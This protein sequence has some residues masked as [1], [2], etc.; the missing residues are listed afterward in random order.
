MKN[1]FPSHPCQMWV[2]I[3]VFAV[4]A[5]A[6]GAAR[7]ETRR[8]VTPRYQG[9]PVDRCLYSGRQCNQP[10]ADAFC[11]AV[12]YQRATRYQWQYMAPTRILGTGHICNTPGR[13]GCGGF[14]L[15]DCSRPSSSQANTR[16]FNNPILRGYH[17]DRC[18]YYGRQ[19]NQPAADAFCRAVGYSRA[20]HYQWRYMAPTRIL[21]TGQICNVP[22]RG[23]CGGF[24]RV[25]C[26]RGGLR[27]PPQAGGKPGGAR[28]SGN[29]ECRSGICLLGVCA[30]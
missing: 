11:R 10:A 6:S 1:L 21:G 24:T 26:A 25:T 4:V 17:V 22:G 23:G 15:V 2:L 19:C 30:H 12:G 13:R 29:N 7:A 20:T 3:L 8:F 16:T 9:Y 28:C 5:T 18:L 14:T 27:P